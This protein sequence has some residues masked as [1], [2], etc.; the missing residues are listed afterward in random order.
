MKG[1]SFINLQED[2]KGLDYV[3]KGK[4]SGEL[5]KRGDFWGLI[6]ELL[7]QEYLEGSLTSRRV[8]CC[9]KHHHI[10]SVEFDLQFTC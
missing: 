8:R 3:F 10:L 9:I 7:C 6:L 4:S 5:C 2:T 1:S